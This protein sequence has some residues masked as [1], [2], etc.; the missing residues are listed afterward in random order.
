LRGQETEIAVILEKVG[1]ED[2][3]VEAI[4]PDFPNHEVDSLI[5][6]YPEFKEAMQ[7]DRAML[8]LISGIMFAMAAIGILNIMMMAVFERT[9]EMGVLAAMGM[10]G[11]QIVVLFVL[12]GAFIGLVSGV[13]GGILSW[14][15]VAWVGQIG[16][17][18]SFVQDAGEIYA[19]MGDRFY[20]AITLE[21]IL[22]FGGAAVIVGALAALFPARRAARREPAES[23]HHV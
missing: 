9:R 14:L 18:F 16:I 19:L 13:I 5:T 20:P 17:D 4:A 3:L 22:Q 6:L 2:A 10:K 15:L 21:T 1:Q 12:E 7:T 23:L 8:V 11:R